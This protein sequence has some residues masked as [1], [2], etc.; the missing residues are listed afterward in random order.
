MATGSE[1]PSE[2]AGEAQLPTKSSESGGT[3]KSN[4]K[5]AYSQPS[6]PK[7][8]KT[9]PASTEDMST[10]LQCMSSSSPPTG[11]LDAGWRFGNC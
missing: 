7:T 6:S 2:G 3:I 8:P 1:G 4:K 5:A 11:E 10:L 9:I